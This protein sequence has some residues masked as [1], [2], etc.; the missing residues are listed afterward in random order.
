LIRLSLL[1]DP[2]L[3]TSLAM[4]A[5]VSTVMMATLVVGPS[6]LSHGLG[7]DVAI[8]GFAMSAGPLVSALMGVPAGLVVDRLFARRMT[9]VGLSGGSAG[10]WPGAWHWP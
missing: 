10:C 9:R 2:V 7:L 4:S 6:Y 8:V 1:C 3:T 5:L